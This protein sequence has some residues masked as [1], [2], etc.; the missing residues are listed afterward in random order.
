ML[1]KLYTAVFENVTVAAVQ[2]LFAIKAGSTSGIAIRRLSLSAGGVTS[3]A[4]IRVRLKRLMGTVTLG[5]GGTVP[6]PQKVSSTNPYASVSTVH[7]NDTTQATS[8]S[9]DQSYFLANWQ[10]MVLNEFCEIPPTEDERWEC[11]ANEAL[12]LEV[13][14]NPA[15]TVISGFACWRDT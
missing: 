8:G 13:V 10:W 9:P 14:S 7:C 12:V 1:F 4:E 11:E 3:A 5:S 6:T 2:D 15:S